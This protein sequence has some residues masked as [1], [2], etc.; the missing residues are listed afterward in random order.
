[1]YSEV[2]P[3]FLSTFT[4]FKYLSSSW[5]VEFSTR[6]DEMKVEAVSALMNEHGG[7]SRIIKH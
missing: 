1:M 2:K 3:G 6:L 4:N 7:V 5:S